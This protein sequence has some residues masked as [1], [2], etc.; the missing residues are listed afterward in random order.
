M[1]N[2]EIGFSL[3]LTGIALAVCVGA[4]YMMVVMI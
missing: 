2:F 1:S 4:V 3:V